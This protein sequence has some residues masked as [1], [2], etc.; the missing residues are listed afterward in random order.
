[1]RKAVVTISIGNQHQSV[2]Q[3]T[4]P[5][6][7]KYAHRIG[8]GFELITEKKVNLATPHF[9]KFQL[10]DLL[11]KYD[12]ILF[13]DDDVIITPGC[14]DIFEAV[15]ETEIGVFHVH[16]V[17][18]VFDPAIREAQDILGEI[19][20]TKRYFNS[21]VMVVS[22]AHRKLFERAEDLVLWAEERRKYHEQTLLNYRMVKQ[23]HQVRDFGYRFNH[24]PPVKEHD[25]LQSHI[26]HYAAFGHAPGNRFEQ[27]VRDMQA[28]GMISRADTGRRTVRVWSS[29]YFLF[30][31]F[32]GRHSANSADRV[33]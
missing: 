31:L 16:E 27:I 1:M 10:F 7:C 6:I 30:R 9:E 19:G 8:A 23:K 24:V 32:P 4:V 3:I 28:L 29:L 25:R 11:E 18:P 17:N 13:I 20:W 21:G 5:E 15:K 2:G 22:K 26:I 12:R 14:P 33:R